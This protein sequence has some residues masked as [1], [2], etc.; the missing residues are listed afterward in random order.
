MTPHQRIEHGQQ[1]MKAII[2]RETDDE[3]AQAHTLASD[4]LT[5]LERGTDDWRMTFM[6]FAFLQDEIERRA[7]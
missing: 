4:R 7:A 2:A 5:T 6:T 1:R 3:L